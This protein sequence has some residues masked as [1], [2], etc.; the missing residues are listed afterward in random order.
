MLKYR[1]AEFATPAFDSFAQELYK[2]LKDYLRKFN[3]KYWRESFEGFAFTKDGIDYEYYV[4]PTVDSHFRV[5]FY[6]WDKHELAG[7]SDFEDFPPNVCS[8]SLAFAWIIKHYK[9][10]LEYWQI[11]FI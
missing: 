11:T 5:G 3:L 7:H 2:H 8:V 9:F 6:A 1:N 4:Y 10:K